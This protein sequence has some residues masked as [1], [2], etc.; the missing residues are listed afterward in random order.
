MNSSW[1]K[2]SWKKLCIKLQTNQA[3]CNILG[4]RFEKSSFIKE[5]S[6]AGVKIELD[7]QAQIVN[8]AKLEHHTIWPHEPA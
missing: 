1:I 2:L 5:T 8:R 7:F 6:R 3:V 4:A